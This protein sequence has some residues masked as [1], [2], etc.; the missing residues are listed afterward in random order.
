MRRSAAAVALLS[1]AVPV[2]GA[3]AAR[4]LVSDKAQDGTATVAVIQGNVPRLGLDFNSQRR[5]VLDYHARETERL[6][7]EDGIEAEV[8]DPR[9]LVPLDLAAIVE[10][11]QRTSRLVVAHEAV[12]HGGFGA[13]VAAQVQSAAFDFLDAPVVRGTQL[14]PSHVAEMIVTSIAIPPVSLY[15]R[16]RGALHF[17][18]LFL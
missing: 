10:S 13:E 12:A 11:V 14:T 2:V 15:W 5:A 1:V 18:V 8:I 17:R 6:A 16:M 3:L 7:A 9:T 4:T